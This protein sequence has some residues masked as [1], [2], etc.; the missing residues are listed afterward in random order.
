MF[1]P[2]DTY[3]YNN[4]LVIT[5]YQLIIKHEKSLLLLLLYEAYYNVWTVKVK[6]KIIIQY[7]AIFKINALLT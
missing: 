1:I 2:N 7:I 3:W 4:W 6:M 5:D